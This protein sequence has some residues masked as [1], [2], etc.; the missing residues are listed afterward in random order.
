M[1]I[2][3]DW[4]NSR[5]AGE[6]PPSRKGGRTLESIPAV[7][8]TDLTNV[9]LFPLALADIGDVEVAKSPVEARSPRVAHAKGKDFVQSGRPYKGIVGRHR[10]V[11]GGIAGKVVTMHVDAQDF[12]EQA[13]DVLPAAQRVAS[14]AAVAQRGIE[15]TVGSE[16]E[17]S[18]LVIAEVR[19]VDGQDGR[20]ACSVGDVWIRRHVVAADLGVPAHI[21]QVDVEE[22]VAGEGWIEGETEQAAL[23]VRQDLARYIEERRCK[24]L[25]R[26]KIQNFDQPGFFDDE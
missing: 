16:A 21:D 15:I 2:G 24:N 13:V 22:T 26:G 19:L 23:P 4:R 9:D 18:A 8:C 1:V 10:I 5:C 7:V 12:A 20:S 11:S 3:V 25:S 17:P 14:A 6:G